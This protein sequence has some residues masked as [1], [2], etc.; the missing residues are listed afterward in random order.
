[1]QSPKSFQIIVTY[2]DRG[3]VEVCGGQISGKPKETVS[4]L[5]IQ[6]KCW[7]V[8]I[9]PPLVD[10]LCPM[11]P[12]RKCPPIRLIADL[13]LIDGK[14][15]ELTDIQIGFGRRATDP[16]RGRRVTDGPSAPRPKIEP[17]P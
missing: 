2:N 14:D 10:P 3:E 4:G 15:P 13:H 7:V 17:K 8:P 16:P 6:Q 9:P 12:P 5:T 11:T 1:M